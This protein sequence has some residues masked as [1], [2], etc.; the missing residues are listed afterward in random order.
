MISGRHAH[1]CSGTAVDLSA[2][3]RRGLRDVRSFPQLLLDAQE[4]VYFATRSERAGA[5]VLI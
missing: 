3:L 4:L 2:E 5:L 1:G